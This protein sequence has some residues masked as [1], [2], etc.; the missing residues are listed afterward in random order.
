MSASELISFRTLLLVW[1]QRTDRAHRI[2]QRSDVSVFRLVTNS[3]VEEKIL[4]RA[5]EKLNTAALVVE[6]G[7]FN[8]GSVENDNSLERKQL[9]EILLTDFDTSTAQAAAASKVQSAGQS[10]KSGSDFGDEDDNNSAASDKEDLNELLSNNE[11]DYQM[12]AAHDEKRIRDGIPLAEL[13]TSPDDVPDWIKY[14]GGK[15]KHKN[16]NGSLLDDTGDG[17]RKRKAVTY[18]DGLT[19]KQFIRLMEKQAIEDEKQ[20]SARKKAR[21]GGKFSSSGGDGE[22]EELADGDA[23]A[24]LT[25]WTFRKLINCTKNVITLKDPATKRRLAELFLEKPAPQQFPDYYELIEKPIAINDILR[26]CRGKL[27]TYYKEYRDDWR[28]MVANAIKFNGE[29]SWVV[30]DALALEKELDRVMKRNGFSEESLPSPKPPKKPK[31]LRIK[32]SLKTVKQPGEGD[33]EGGGAVS[34][35]AE[36]EGPPKKK[37]GRKPKAKKTP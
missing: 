31:K 24:E 9:M 34:S 16:Q 2:G 36:A 28:L 12:Y 27:Y 32:L 3:P 10:E 23:G 15:N 26:K 14:P 19:E 30:Q 11:N 13:Y 5:S 17:S 33:G 7:K 21:R 25:D 18:D 29:D 1:P 37:R 20:H 35:A 8:K 4:S 22:D 6:A